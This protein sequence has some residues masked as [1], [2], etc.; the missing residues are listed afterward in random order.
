MGWHLER[1]VSRTQLI[2]PPALSCLP[3]SE[4]GPGEPTLGPRRSSA[5]S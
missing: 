1:E 5:I 3:A 4:L 2:R